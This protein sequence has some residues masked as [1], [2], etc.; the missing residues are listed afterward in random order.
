MRSVNVVFLLGD[1]ALN[2][3]LS[4]T[5]VSTIILFTDSNCSFNLFPQMHSFSGFHGS[6]FP[7]LSCGQLCLSSSNGSS[8]PL[9]HFG[10]HTHFSTCHPHMLLYGKPCSKMLLPSPS[11]DS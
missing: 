4:C 1:T 10:G 11:Y 7:T 5:F 3:L 2:C 9:F 8:M 6:E